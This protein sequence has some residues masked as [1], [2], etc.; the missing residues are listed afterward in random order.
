MSAVAS[1]YSYGIASSKTSVLGGG[2]ATRV[3]I[4]YSPN[5]PAGRSLVCPSLKP[6]NRRLLA[7]LPSTIKSALLSDCN[8]NRSRPSSYAA[9]SRSSILASRI[10]VCKRSAIS[11]PDMPGAML[12][13]SFF[14]SENGPSKRTNASTLTGLPK[15]CG[16]VR[17][18][19]SAMIAASSGLR[20][21]SK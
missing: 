19:V 13:L 10:S 1:S 8:I 20:T 7:K 16:S 4:E 17:G 11:A 2:N 5:G 15:N 14:G 18:R 6:K 21:C 12:M 9:N 3:P